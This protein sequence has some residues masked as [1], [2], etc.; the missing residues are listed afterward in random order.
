MLGTGIVGRTLS[1]RLTELSHEVVMGARNADNP[2]AAGWLASV[3]TARGARIGTFGDAAAHGEL[4]I[5]A[6]AGVGSLAALAQAGAPNLNGK[7][8][9]DV[10]NPLDFSRGF[11]PNLAVAN[12]DSLGERIQRGFPQVMVVKALN[13][14]H[15]DLM[16]HPAA[17]PEE[18]TVLVAGEDPEAKATVTDLLRDFG[19]RS[20]LD[21]GGIAAA[22]GMEMYLP[23]WLS[24][25]RCLGTPMFN[26][27]VVRA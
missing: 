20:I 17:L 18:H 4:V 7:V 24:L 23:L 19:W 6:T 15:A 12:T 26:L 21:L 5:N 1:T 11:P 3:G 14:V 9:I 8:L 25:T 27:R 10:S 22:R 2:N 13:T 16:V